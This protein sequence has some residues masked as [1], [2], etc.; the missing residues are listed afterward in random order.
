MLIHSKNIWKSFYN[1]DGKFDVLKGVFLDINEGERIAITGRN[2]TGKT[3]L[4]KILSRNLDF[5]KGELEYTGDFP[6]LFLDQ[7]IEN[8]LAPGL[9]VFEHISICFKNVQSDLKK[10]ITSA[11]K[12]KVKNL[13]EKY[14]LP[15]ESRLNNYIGHLSGGEKQI[16]AITCILAQNPKVLFLDEF[17]SSLD[18]TTTTLLIKILK[19][20][21]AENNAAIVFIS[22]DNQVVNEFSNK[23]IS[24]NESSF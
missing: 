19:T 13:I 3:T 9:T 24:L 17:T 1:I 4:L 16:V 18:I 6:I 7:I 21:T 5:D 11:N 10:L 14:N 22:H 15:I 23:T 20:Y 2:G 8:F 12:G